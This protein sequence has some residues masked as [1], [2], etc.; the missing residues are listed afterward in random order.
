MKPLN[1]TE[2]SKRVIKYIRCGSLTGFT[3]A[4]LVLF[5]DVD[6]TLFSW[7]DTN[8]DGLNATIFAFFVIAGVA[9]G[10]L[11]AMIISW[12]KCG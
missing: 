2:Q 8:L 4:V 11:F 3:I 10:G 1:N 7:T 5:F 9:A 6:G 12:R